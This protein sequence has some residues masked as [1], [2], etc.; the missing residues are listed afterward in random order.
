M[1][2]F[3][4]QLNE[5]IQ[6]ANAISQIRNFHFDLLISCESKVIYDSFKFYSCLCFVNFTFFQRIRLYFHYKFLKVY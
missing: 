4:K 5:N 6:R 1:S 2:N 3:F